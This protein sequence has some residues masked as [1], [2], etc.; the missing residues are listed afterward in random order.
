MAK[1]ARF[2]ALLTLLAFG[3]CA[4]APAASAPAHW[5]EPQPGCY[6]NDAV[7]AGVRIGDAPGAG[8][9]AEAVPNAMARE[10]VTEVVQSHIEEVR[11]CYRRGLA[12][13]PNLQGDVVLRFVVG[14][15]GRVLVSQVASS[16][17][18]DE[19]VG[20]C[21]GRAVCRWL[22][23]APRGGRPV[24]VGYPFSLS[25]TRSLPAEP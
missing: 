16:T 8:D 25:A 4:S 15:G 12:R 19:Q 6:L 22:F 2:P 11:H 10:A 23:E 3:G 7:A 9:P 1:G 14:A 5:D 18:A 24:T 20:D 21:I 13:D 17:V